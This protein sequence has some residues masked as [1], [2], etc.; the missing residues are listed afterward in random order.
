MTT[1]ILLLLT[2]A[3]FATSC[4][5]WVYC[6]RWGLR[7][8]KAAK[9]SKKQIT[10][11][12]LANCM[13][14]IGYLI[15]SKFLTDV[16]VWGE[17][18]VI[19]LQVALL[20]WVI[21]WIFGLTFWRG[22]QA[23][24]PTLLAAAL[25]LILVLFIIKPYVMEAFTN[26]TNSMAPTILGQHVRGVCPT[27]GEK[28]Y[29]TSF[30]EQNYSPTQ[31]M[32]CERFHITESAPKEKKVNQKDRFIVAKYLQPR[33]WDLV[34]FKVP[35]DPNTLFVKRLIGL[36]GEKIH[37]KDGA[38]WVN[39]Q[40]LDIPE[41]LQGLSYQFK[42][43]PSVYWGSEQ[44]PAQLGADEYFV[45]GDFSTNSSDSRFWESGVSG[46]QPFAVPESHLAGVVTHTYW[47]LYRWRIHR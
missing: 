17:L 11:A 26:A 34:V 42:H 46:H 23:W 1:C 15:V 40:R 20:C 7:W 38:V 36:P 27:C 30:V 14:S 13:V 22:V 29:G 47:P 44:Q 28:N 9:I 31:T 43:T 18:A 45:L 10:L 2:L 25:S 8:A 24:L 5:L 4:A 12:V 39:D 41:H 21:A 6:L 32:I 3:M 35:Y 16:T 37:I 33:R 19:L